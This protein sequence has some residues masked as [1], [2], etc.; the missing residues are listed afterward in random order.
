MGNFPLNICLTKPHGEILFVYTIDVVLNSRAGKSRENF[1]EGWCIK[2]YLLGLTMA[3]DE[4]Q[5]LEIEPCHCERA[6]MLTTSAIRTTVISADVL[7]GLSVAENDFSA[8]HCNINDPSVSVFLR[9]CLLYLQ[10]AFLSFLRRV[11]FP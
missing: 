5:C 10:L 6:V 9:C 1:K 8:I 7:G 11:T 4:E 2:T 3:L